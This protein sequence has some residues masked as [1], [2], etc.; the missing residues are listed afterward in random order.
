MNSNSASGRAVVVG[1]DGSRSSDVALD[2]AVEEAARRGLQMHIIHAFSTDCPLTSTRFGY[3]INRLRELAANVRTDSVLRARCAS[4]DLA[5]TWEQ[6]TSSPAAALVCASETADTLV[7]GARGMGA[8]RGPLMGSV[9]VQVA[10]HAHCPV[11]VVH[12]STTPAPARAP[13]VVGID[14]SVSSRSAIAYA[15]EQASSRG[16]DLNVLHAWWVDYGEADAG[17]SIQSVDWQRFAQ[18]DQDLLAESLTGWQEKYPDVT[19]R[20]HSLRAFPVGAL[21]HASKKACLVVVGTRGC[22]G[23][24]GL[25]LG[26]VS[27]GVMHRAHCPVAI[28]HS[29]TDPH[30]IRHNTDTSDEHLLPVPAAHVHN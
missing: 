16:V 28:V 29:P 22:G 26:S 27:H 3:S 5:I 13:V 7:V 17:A 24:A 10:E 30:H 6:L 23:F 19:V 21:A 14:G 25:A 18:E 12:Q 11:V 1:V 9:S 4:R 8:A 20:R 2:W 15:F